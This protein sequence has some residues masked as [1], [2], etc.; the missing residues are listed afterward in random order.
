[1]HDGLG[2]EFRLLLTKLRDCSGNVLGLPDPEAQDLNQSYDWEA[3]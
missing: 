1:M 2:P 3:L